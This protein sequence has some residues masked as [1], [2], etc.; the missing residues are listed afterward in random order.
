M[1]YLPS[2]IAT[3]ILQRRLSL[4]QPFT[5]EALH[6]CDKSYN[7]TSAFDMAICLCFVKF[8]ITKRPL[9]GIYVLFVIIMHGRSKLFNESSLFALIFLKFR[10]NVHIISKSK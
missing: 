8:N 9:R 7:R 3:S 5:V 1:C 2:L 10:L 4:L 6:L